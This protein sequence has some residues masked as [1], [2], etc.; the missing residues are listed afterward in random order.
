[1]CNEWSS[2]QVTVDP[3][4]SHICSEQ[5]L[6]SVGLI[7]EYIRL[8]LRSKRGK[9]HKLNQAY[10]FALKMEKVSCK[11]TTVMVLKTNAPVGAIL[12]DQKWTIPFPCD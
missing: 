2:F 11:I 4:R 8:N 7:F 6:E 1:L 5:N 12:P 9:S 10:L 3:G